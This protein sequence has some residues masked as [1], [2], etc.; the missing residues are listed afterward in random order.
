[1]KLNLS[2]VALLITVLGLVWQGSA[3]LTRLETAIEIV[4][5]LRTELKQIREDVIVLRSHVGSWQAEFA[6]RTR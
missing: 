4:P 1:V 3:K 2:I 6:K 5:E